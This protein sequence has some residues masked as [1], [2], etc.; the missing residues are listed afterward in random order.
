[1]RGPSLFSAAASILI[2]L[3]LGFL[4]PFILMTGSWIYSFKTI[5]ELL[6]RIF[7]NPLDV[8]RL[9]RLEDILAAIFIVFLFVVGILVAYNLSVLT[10]WLLVRYALKPRPLGKVTPHRPT[11]NAFSSDVLKDIEKIGIVLA[12]GGAKGAFQAG[13]MKAIYQFL[14]ENNALEKVKVISATSIGS[15][16]ALFWLTDLITSERGWDH[17]SAHETW[18][19]SISLKSLIAPSWYVPGFRNAFFVTTPWQRQFDCL[20]GENRV[21]EKIVR[22]DI[23]FYFTRSHVRSGK[24]ECTTNNQEARD[25]P[26]VSFTRI[27]P[28]NSGQEF[29]EAVKEGVFASMDL[30]PLFPYIEMADEEYEDGG[31][32]DN[33]PVMFAAMEACDLIFVLP[34]N[35]DFNAEPNHRSLLSRFI[36]VMDVRQGALE[37][38]NLKSLYLYNELAVLRKYAQTL[39]GILSKADLALPPDI[40]EMS[41]T[42]KRALSRNHQASR[43]F[44]I[45]PQRTLVESTIDTAEFWKSREAGRAFTTMYRGTRRV[46]ENHFDSKTEQIEMALI[47]PADIR[48]A[49]DF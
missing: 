12:G 42:L 7:G 9:H 23:H 4:I 29:L 21:G 19:R 30:P 33:L 18:W 47:D 10:N 37:R 31:V 48:W 27:S 39:E 34:L 17:G 28:K 6:P 1:V 14:V 5:K 20:F 11:D 24:L 43:L 46:L 8:V 22:S 16:N 32:I 41:A 3:P 35:S 44:G 49:R 13:A 38:G 2:R 15:W 26:R 45:C 40:G 36:R 25:L